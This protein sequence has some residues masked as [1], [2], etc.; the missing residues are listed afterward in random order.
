M[1]LRELQHQKRVLSEPHHSPNGLHFPFLIIEAKGSAVGTNLV[2]AQNQ[3]AVGAACALNILRNL[4]LTAT[5][6]MPCTPMD[7]PE[8]RQIIFSVTAEGPVHELWVHYRIDEEYHMT[9][10]RI[11]L[12]T[13]KKI[14]ACFREGVGMGCV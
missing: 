4:K 7:E 2:G 1:I 3:A 10:L 5:A 6:C 12:T 13:F 14:Y 11:W 9:L 8:P